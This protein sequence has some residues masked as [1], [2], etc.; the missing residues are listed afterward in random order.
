MKISSKFPVFKACY[1]Q[2]NKTCMSTSHPQQR[3]FFLKR[4]SNKSVQLYLPYLWTNSA[5]AVKD[6]LYRHIT[7]NLKLIMKISITPG[8]DNS[9]L[10]L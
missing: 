5:N 3:Y 1:K 9:H 6:K 2:F 8:L 10:L 7:L 4:E